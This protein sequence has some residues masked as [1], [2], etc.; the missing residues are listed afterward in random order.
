MHEIYGIQRM[1]S[2]VAEEDLKVL[3]FIHNYFMA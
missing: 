2:K 1:Y 3:K